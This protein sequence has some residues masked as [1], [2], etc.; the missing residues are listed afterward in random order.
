MEFPA[1]PMKIVIIGAGAIGG[2]LGA[3]MHRDGHDITLCDVDKA[4]VDAINEHGLTIEGPI[5]QFTAKV[6]AITPDDLPPSIDCAIVAVK[7]VHTRTC[8]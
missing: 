6:P 7:S 1:T 4:H 8:T 2:T 3:L 5:N